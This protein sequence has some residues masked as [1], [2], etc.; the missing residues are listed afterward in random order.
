ME[1]YKQ[2]LPVGTKLCGTNFTYRI[3]RLLGQGTYNITY[4]AYTKVALD[5]IGKVQVDMPVVVK[6]FFVL[7]MSGRSGRTVTAGSKELFDKFRR[8]FAHEMARLASLDYPGVV[9]MIDSFD[10]YGTSYY[11]MEYCDGGTLDDRIAKCGGLAQDEALRYFG[12]IASAL[13]YMHNRGI[14]FLDMSPGNV[15]LR[16]SGGALLDFNMSHRLFDAVDHADNGF[17]TYFTCYS[18]LERPNYNPD[19]IGGKL[20]VTMDVYALGATLY[21]MLTG[22]RPPLAADILMDGLSEQPLRDHGVSDNVIASIRRA[23]QPRAKDR[24]QSVADFA[25]AISC[26]SI[27]PVPQLRPNPAPPESQV[28]NKGALAIGTSL[29][30]GRY[31]IERV[32]GQG[33]FGITYLCQHTGL[34]KQV[35]IKEFFFVQFCERQGDTS[36]VMVPTVGNR[37]LV[38]KFRLKFV[39]EARLIASKLSQAPSVVNVFDV[40][41]ENGTSYYVMDYIDGLSLAEVLKK[42]GRLGEV[43]AVS[44]IEQVGKA[45]AYVHSRGI[46]H[47]DIKPANIM[48]NRA[49]GQAALID[50]GVAKQYDATTGEAT[51]TTPVGRTP[52]YAPLEQYSLSGVSSFTPQSDIYALGATLYKLVTGNTPPE[53][54]AMPKDAVLPY[55]DDISAPVRRAITVAM[56]PHKED[57]PAKVEDFLQLL[58]S[59]PKPINVKIDI[60]EIPEVIVVDAVRS[61]VSQSVPNL[62][63]EPTPTMEPI[64]PQNNLPEIEMVYVE[65]GTFTMGATSEQDDYAWDDEKPAHSVTLDGYYIGKYEVTQELWEAVMGSNPSHFKG[66]NL[67]VECVSWDDVQEFLRKLNAM[68]GKRYRLPTEAEWEFAARGGNGSRG[69]KYSGSNSIDDVAWF[70]Y[71]SGCPNAVGTKSP[72]ELGIYDMSGNVWEWCHD[73]KGDY[74]CYPQRNPKGPNSGACRVYRG[75]SWLNSARYCRVSHRDFIAP[76]SRDSRLGFRLAL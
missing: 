4:L 30:G 31:V 12:Q 54:T 2:V 22:R 34:G 5:A 9:K 57:R 64:H 73:W 37:E 56:Q 36:Q 3:D 46:N 19:D 41:D 21:K 29:Q 17:L 45:L 58:H 50:F 13:S 8:K 66:D 72:N 20:P 52:G 28:A 71:N 67:P 39:K 1:V 53:A 14:L 6:E 61:R 16:N 42:R 11:V 32:L 15:L 40:F 48:I 70:Y 23:M 49:S 75:G 26:E 27:E 60:E 65:G 63:P 18:P 76:D 44:I 51:T 69:C 55:P 10:T 33:G 47:L 59:Q 43:E 7:G 24:Y 62:D 68:T 35:A 25:A 74:S 38:E